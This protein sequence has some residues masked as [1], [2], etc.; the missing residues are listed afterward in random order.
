M[1][2]DYPGRYRNPVA[3]RKDPQHLDIRQALR[4]LRQRGDRCVTSP[5]N[6]A[7]FWNTCTRPASARGGFGLT[8]SEADRRLRI[9]ERLFPILPES[10]A[11]YAQW[12]ALV[13]SHGVMGVQAHDARLA[14]M[15]VHGLTHLLTLNPSDFGRYSIVALTPAAILTGSP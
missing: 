11:A 8:V 1:T 3:E 7:E 12:R 4:L 15:M 9:L 10:P 13:V 6:V 14:L 2:D 5:Q